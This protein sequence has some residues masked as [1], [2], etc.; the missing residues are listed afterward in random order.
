MTKE[1][2]RVDLHLH[3][4]IAENTLRHDGDHV[5]IVDGLTDNEWRR[6]VVGIGGAR[7][8]RC[9]ERPGAVH[10]V[11]VPCV[12]LQKRHRFPRRGWH[13]GRRPRACLPRCSTGPGRHRIEFCQASREAGHPSAFPLIACSSFEGVTGTEVIRTPVAYFTAFKSAGA[14]GINTCSPNPLAP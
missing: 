3:T 2:V 12:I 1:P 11:A 8:H 6:L 9:H 14:V 13:S 5:S 4:A 7:A 10:K